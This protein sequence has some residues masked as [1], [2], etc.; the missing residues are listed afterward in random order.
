MRQAAVGHGETPRFC[1]AGALK[2]GLGRMQSV[3]ALEIV[4]QTDQSPLTRSIGQTTQRE[5]AEAQHLLDDANN[6]FDRGFA[7]AIE[8]IADAGTEFVGHFFF[9]GSIFG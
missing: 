5:L 3:Q 1:V 6:R 9:G 4:G 2:R 8:S 7:Q